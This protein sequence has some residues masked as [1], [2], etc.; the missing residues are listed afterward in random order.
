MTWELASYASKSFNRSSGVQA[1]AFVGEY[2]GVLAFEVGFDFGFLY[3]VWGDG[4]LESEV[5]VSG[6]DLM[7]RFLD[8]VGLDVMVICL[9]MWFVR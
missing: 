3:G 2:L 4:E 7:V 1:S 5:L 9:G 8:I 6:S